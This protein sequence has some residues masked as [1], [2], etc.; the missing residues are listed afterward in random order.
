VRRCFKLLGRAF[1]LKTHFG[2]ARPAFGG[3]RFC[4]PGVMLASRRLTDS[5]PVA[6]VNFSL[7][8]APKAL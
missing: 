4:V 1:R 8:E 2:S 5:L 7:A 3:L 6:S